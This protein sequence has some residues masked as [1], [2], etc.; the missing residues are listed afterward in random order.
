MSTSWL[1]LLVSIPFFRVYIHTYTYMLQN[2]VLIM[3]I[4]IE[5]ELL[6]NFV[7][8]ILKLMFR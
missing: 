8:I 1:I 6:R 5:L 7:R 2:Y 3:E 4:I